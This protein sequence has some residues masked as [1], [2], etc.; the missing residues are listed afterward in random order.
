MLRA[1]AAPSQAG[2]CGCVWPGAKGRRACGN[3]A[4]FVM[5]NNC[6]VIGWVTAWRR[7]SSAPSGSSRMRRRP[8]PGG[9]AQARGLHLL[10]LLGQL[11]RQEAA[12]RCPGRR[13]ARRRFAPLAQS[14]GNGDGWCAAQ[15]C[16]LDAG[17]L[18]PRQARS[19]VPDEG[20]GGLRQLVRI[21]TAGASG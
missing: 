10:S 17:P 4:T 3:Q 15:A 21:G 16:R 7:G 14:W 1:I 20:E 9:E 13:P 5:R 19:A 6:E 11:P 2:C 12:L 8:S 18:P